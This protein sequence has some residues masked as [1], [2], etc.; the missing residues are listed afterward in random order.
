MGVEGVVAFPAW[1]EGADA[2]EPEP[3]VLADC[4]RSA[5]NHT[6]ANRPIA[7]RAI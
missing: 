7:S 3:V 2:E 4:P 6:A 1:A 5:T